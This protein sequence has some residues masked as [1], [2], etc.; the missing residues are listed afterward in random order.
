[1][2]RDNTYICMVHDSNGRRVEMLRD[3]ALDE[4]RH[5]FVV[6]QP[7]QV[8]RTERRRGPG[9]GTTNTLCD[10]NKSSDAH[11]LCPSSKR[12]NR[13]FSD[14]LRGK[15]HHRITSVEF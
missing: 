12:V 2:C 5:V 8:E 10:T 3:A 11:E 4:E 1:M 13:N 7:Q 6:Q 9:G 14:K 15:P